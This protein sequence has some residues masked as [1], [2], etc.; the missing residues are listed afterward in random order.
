MK[1]NDL[2][3]GLDFAESKTMPVNVIFSLKG[4]GQSNMS[5][6]RNRY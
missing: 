1:M 6:M 5:L 2:G 3:R 4:N